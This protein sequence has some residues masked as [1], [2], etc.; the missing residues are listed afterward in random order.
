MLSL[1]DYIAQ[2]INLIVPVGSRVTCNPPPM[3]TDRDFLVLVKEI[4]FNNLLFQL[5]K[6]DFEIGGSRVYRRGLTEDDFAFQS[7]TKG[8][9]NLIVT[10][11]PKFFDKFIKATNIARDLN[12]LNKQDRIDLFQEVLYDVPRVTQWKKE[13]DKYL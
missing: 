4:D 6:E 11:S 5:L 2:L 10:A 3:D 8:D 12:L 1:N 13:W 7:Y 9:I